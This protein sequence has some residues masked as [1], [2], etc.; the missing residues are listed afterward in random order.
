[1]NSVKTDEALQD[2]WETNLIPAVVPDHTSSSPHVISEQ[3]RTTLSSLPDGTAA[4]LKGSV[5]HYTRR[6]HQPSKNPEVS[7]RLAGVEEVVIS[8]EQSFLHCVSS[9]ATK[10]FVR[11]VSKGEESVIFEA[12]QAASTIWNFGS[13]RNVVLRADDVPFARVCFKEKHYCI[14]SL[15]LAV[16]AP[17]ESLIGTVEESSSCFVLSSEFILGDS[18]GDHLFRINCDKGFC[19]SQFFVTSLQNLDDSNDQVAQILEK[20]GTSIRVKFVAKMSITSK[21]ILIGFCI[22]AIHKGFCQNMTDSQS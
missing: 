22:G 8:L 6:T 5:H 11:D 20:S 19:T 10:Y 15:V 12:T 16:Y 17:P 3:P 14:E 9:N 18:N 7:A 4:E 13:L 21:L 1:M 2:V